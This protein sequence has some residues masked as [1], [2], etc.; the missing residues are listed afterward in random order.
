MAKNLYNKDSIESL[1]P[2]EFTRLRPGVYAGDTTYSTQ[3]LVEIISNAVDEFR[4]GH[5]DK[6]EVIVNKD[7][8]SV[9]DYGQGFIPNSFRDD[10]KT[11][12]EA[13]FSVL[14]TSGKYREDGTYEGTSL[15]SFGIGSKITTFLSH[16]LHVQ[17]W[18]DDESELIFFKEGVF[19]TR[20][21]NQ[22]N[23]EPTGTF[24]QW[25]PSE[26]FFTNTIVEMSKIKDLFKT[27][28][29]LCPGLKILLNDNGTEYIY[30]S[31]KGINDLVD[32]IVKDKELIDNRFN[33]KYNFGKEKL[34][35]VLTY[36]S[37]YSSVIVPYVNTGLTEKGPHITQIKTLLTR[38]FN[39]FFRDKKWLKEKE[40]NLS[41]DDIQ[42]GMLI[43]FNITAPNVTYDAQVKSNVTKIELGNLMKAL[44]DNLQVWFEN[45]E[46]DVKLIAD[47]AL[48]ARRAREAA[49]KARDAARNTETKGKSKLLNLPTKLVDSWSK[50]REKCELLVAEGDSAASGL[51]GARDG[52][53]QAVFPI[54]GKI[55]NLFKA[56]LE[57]T[58]ANQEVVNI[59][60]ALG[61]ELNPKTNKMIYDPDKLRYGKVIMACDADADGQAIK[62]LL[63]TCFWSLCPE[64]IINGHI[65]AA[66]PPLFRITTRKNEYIYLRDAVALEKYKIEHA[67]EKYAVNRNKG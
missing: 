64:L 32:I 34:D 61:L 58:M 14:N 9:R 51:I 2:L 26:E 65:Y 13:A 21:K 8:V 6:I 27:I 37:N 50:D 45:N 60:K 24:V 15:G 67:N 43:V 31:E 18:R 3:L 4:A 20:I 59:I 55:L 12:L 41:G 49:K 44:S 46:K 16:W 25:Q 10:G 53:F 39:K 63:L 11:I 23:D 62:N 33:F 17:T 57:K 5:G 56:S 54:R 29:C 28:S 42:E 38:D 52:E 47:K 66:V 48:A 1:S 36:T 19:D 7:V 22:E 40:E 30:Y 35:F